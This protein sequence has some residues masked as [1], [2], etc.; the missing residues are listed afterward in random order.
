MKPNIVIESWRYR[1][2]PM[3]SIRL[4]IV[5]TNDVGAS[6]LRRNH[7]FGEPNDDH[8]WTGLCAYNGFRIGLFFER[9]ELCH[10][11][12]AH[13]IF[14]AAHRI[15]ERNGVLFG[16]HNHEP[17]ALLC[18]WLTG[19]VYA[20]LSKMRERVLLTYSTRVYLKNEPRLRFQCYLE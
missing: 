17:F 11:L 19:L 7:L 20:E 8:N 5:V 15:L 2:V 3:H 6:R 16:L 18:G 9:A 1:L 10:D 14:H 12:I 4:L 13:E